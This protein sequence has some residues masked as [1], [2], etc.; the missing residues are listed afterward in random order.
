MLLMFIVLEYRR[1]LVR[2][3][4]EQRTFALLNESHVLSLQV[5]KEK[6]PLEAGNSQ[7]CL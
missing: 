1:D 2:Y 7:K 5:L 3:I 6:D 4:T